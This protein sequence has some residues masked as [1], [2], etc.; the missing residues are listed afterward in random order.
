M[1]WG[2]TKRQ[3]ITILA[4]AIVALIVLIILVVEATSVL[5]HGSMMPRNAMLKRSCANP[6]WRTTRCGLFWWRLAWR[7]TFGVWKN[8]WDYWVPNKPGLH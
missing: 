5:W 6:N 3:G 8:W 4:I 7:I 1:S 2:F